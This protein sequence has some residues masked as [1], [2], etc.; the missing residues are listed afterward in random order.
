VHLGGSFEEIA[1]GEAAVWQGK[2]A[3]APFVLVCQQGAVD[4]SR[5]PAGK[6]VGYAYIHVPAGFRG[7][8]SERI[9]AQIERYAPGFRQRILARHVLGPRDF[10]R[11]NPSHIGGAITGGAA[12]LRQ[13]FTRPVP[14]W[15]PWATPNP[16]L[17]L[18]SH[19]TPPGGGIHGMCGLHAARAVLS[20]RFGLS[21]D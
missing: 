3:E 17:F 1:R 4:P 21:L 16:Q 11:L 8:V 6:Q 2:V 12:N 20:R 19:S 13:L 7:D 9:E 10:E 18:C 15:C 14:A 5:A